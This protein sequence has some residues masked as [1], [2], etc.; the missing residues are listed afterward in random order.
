MNLKKS[1]RSIKY[2]VVH[3]SATPEGREH[4]AKDIARWHKQRGFTEIGYNY[5]I[6]LDGTIELGRDVDKI[7][8]HVEGFNANSIGIVYIGG[9]SSPNPS[10][11]GGKPKD[12]RTK[13]QKQ[14]LLQLLKELRKLYPTAKIWGHRDF[15]NV[16]KACPCF[17]AKKEYNN[18]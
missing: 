4:T 1:K 6:R 13:G 7:P 8:A 3:C 11:G 5:V 17:D 9:V 10:E 18:I 14:S 12:T 2:L 16:K 15:P